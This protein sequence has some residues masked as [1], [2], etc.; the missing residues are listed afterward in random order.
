MTFNNIRP[1]GPKKSFFKIICYNYN[2]KGYYARIYPN[3]IKTI[4]KKLVV[5]LIT[6]TLMI[7]AGKE[8]VL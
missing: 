7:G 1:K 6:S 2:K 3:L 8:V 4:L 5:V